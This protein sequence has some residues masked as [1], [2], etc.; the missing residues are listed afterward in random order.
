MIDDDDGR[1]TVLHAR[2]PRA[3][4]EHRCDECRRAIEP[5]ERYVV[6]RY[7]YEGAATSHKTCRHCDAVRAWLLHECGGFVYGGVADDLGAHLQEGEYG[8]AVKLA[9]AGIERSWRRR[10]GRLWR[11]PSF[12]GVPTPGGDVRAA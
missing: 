11:V 8:A 7:V 6:E 2:R 10:D 9:G 5:G 1:V 3:R 4:R 12:K